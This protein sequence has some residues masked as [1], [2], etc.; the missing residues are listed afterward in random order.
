M[1]LRFSFLSFTLFLFFD[2]SVEQA[3]TIKQ[4]KTCKGKFSVFQKDKTY[5]SPLLKTNK[6][7]MIKATIYMLRS[8]RRTNANTWTTA[9]DGEDRAQKTERER[10]KHA[11]S[12]DR[13]RPSSAIPSR[14]P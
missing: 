14:F 1:F 6:S 13:R 7:K 3:Y 8:R 5:T 10:H 11:Y 12:R 2:F 9:R 4:A